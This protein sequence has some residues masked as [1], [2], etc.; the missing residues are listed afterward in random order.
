MAEISFVPVL[1]PTEIDRVHELIKKIWPSHYTPIIGEA[2][3]EYMLATYQSRENILEEIS[4]KASY[5]IIVYS[6]QDA[7]YLAYE[8]RGDEMYLSKLY[9]LEELRNRGIGRA[10]FGFVEKAAREAGAAKISLNVNKNNTN[11]IE[12]YKKFG[13]TIEREM[14]KDLGQGY[15]MDDYV[16]GKDV[17]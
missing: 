6:G 5:Y 11:S 8:K 14:I 3:V 16:M 10:G 7:G 4:N 1:S 12:A 15:V 2:Q 9:V 17:K 13:F